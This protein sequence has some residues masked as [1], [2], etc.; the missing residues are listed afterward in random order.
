MQK[1]KTCFAM[2]IQKATEYRFDFFVGYVSAVFPII[3]QISMWTAIYHSTATGI[4][5]GYSYQQMILYTFFV[6]VIAKFISTGFEYEMNDDIK[7]GGLNKYLVKPI[8]YCFYRISCFLGERCS[9]SIVF[10]FLLI[11][12]CTMFKFMGYFE[13]S[14]LKI[15]CFLFALML[16][17]LL[18][19]FLYFCIGISGLWISE[20]SRVFPA[21]SIILTI[22]SG[23][24]FPLD[25]LGERFNNLIFFLPFKYLL[26]FP[27][28]IISGKELNYPISIAFAVQIFWV[29][30]L[31]LIAQ[32]LWKKGLKKYIAIGG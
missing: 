31:A 1:Y 11:V 8:N 30:I 15:I 14:V 21:I 26:Q 25:I 13:I 6:G 20:I 17:L 18:N 29:I 23:G 19:F 22:L 4:L 16:S 28:D 5:Y 9:I 12:L 24:I 10:F 27:V 32:M 7:N 2:G 3:I